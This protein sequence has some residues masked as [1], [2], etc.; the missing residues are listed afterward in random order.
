MD[1]DKM[2]VVHTTE[3]VKLLRLLFVDTVHGLVLGYHGTPKAIVT[4]LQEYVN[5]HPISGKEQDDDMVV[6]SVISGPMNSGA[7]KENVPDFM[8]QFFKIASNKSM[9]L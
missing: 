5:N 7:T 2:K 9:Q 6:K 1:E 8:Q 4:A 3:D